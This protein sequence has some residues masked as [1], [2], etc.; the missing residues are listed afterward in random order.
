MRSTAFLLPPFA[1]LA[2][3]AALFYTVLTD[4]GEPA[5]TALAPAEVA[6]TATVEPQFRADASVCQ[7]T[8]ARP[9]AGAPRTFPAMYTKQREHGGLTIVAI[10]SVSDAAFAKAEETIDRTFAHNDLK[11]YLVDQGAYVVIRGANQGVLDLPEF[12]CLADQYQDGFFDHVCGVADHADYPVATV[13]ELDLTGDRDGPCRGLNV[14]Y[15]ELGHLVQGWALGPADYYD[16]KQFYQDAMD[17]GKYRRR[18]AA[19]NANEYF[20]DGTQAYLDSVSP[21]GSD[22]RAWLQRYDPQL[23]TLLERVYGK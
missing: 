21:D 14:L 8:F 1:L 10:D 13:S 6:P 19:T 9:K 20:A 16:V 23:Y 22:D 15:H 18:Y 3:A 12:A 11:Q 2:V 4:N 7:G 17:A 5:R